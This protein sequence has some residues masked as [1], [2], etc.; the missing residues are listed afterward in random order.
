MTKDSGD[1]GGVREKIEAARLEDCAVI[2]V[3]RPQTSV[4]GEFQ[5]IPGLIE[6]LKS[7]ANVPPC[8]VL[9]LD[10]ES[11]L[12]PEIWETVARETGLA[13]LARTTRDI[14]DY[15]VLMRRRISLCRE[16]GLTLVRLREVVAGIEPLPGA[17]AFL[18]WAQK[19]ALVVIVSD[20]FHELAGPM[21]QKLGS[22][23][24]LC[25]SLVFD[26]DGYISD[27]S[28]SDFGGKAGAIARF[29]RL[30]WRVAAVGD[31]F[32]DLEM[33]KAADVA[34]LFCPSPSVLEAGVAFPSFPT[35]D[36]LQSTLAKSLL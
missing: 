25:H 11:V 29:Q 9:A 6:K 13:E 19:R 34:C 18:A 27:Y 30:G 1:A 21:M 16:H 28:L 8:S 2:V 7:V 35:F 17:L 23:M 36:N 12:V 15:G 20:T 3:G 14:P 26:E 32:N 31:S 33:L 4:E 10:L 24:M 5:E 22:P